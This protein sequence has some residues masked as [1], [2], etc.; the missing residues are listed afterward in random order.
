MLKLYY[1]VRKTM[2]SK[3]KL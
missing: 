2:N 3:L 1:N